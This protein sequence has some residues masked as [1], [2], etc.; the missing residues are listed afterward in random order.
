MNFTESSRRKYAFLRR[1]AMVAAALLGVCSL[2]TFG[3]ADII[4]AT[5][6]RDTAIQKFTADGES[7]V[8]SSGVSSNSAYSW[9]FTFDSLGNSYVANT[10]EGSID[11]ITPSG[12]RSVYASGLGWPTNLAFDN[13]GN[14][15]AANCG[16]SSIVKI[17]PDGS[18]SVFA[19]VMY[20]SRGLAFDGSGNLYVGTASA[21]IM[22]FTP[23]GVGAVFARTSNDPFSL[24]F[25][26]SGNLYAALNT[27]GTIERITPGG[28]SSVFASGLKQPSS[29][30]FDSMGNLFVGNYGGYVYNSN[31]DWLG[32][33][34]YIEKITPEG[35][36]SVFASGLNL[37]PLALAVT[38]DAGNPLSLPNDVSVNHAPVVIDN[39]AINDNS[40]GD[41]NAGGQPLALAPEPSSVWALLALCIPVVSGM[42]RQ[43]LRV[44]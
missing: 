10:S 37:L 21:E 29:L 39:P 4:Y 3:R 28:V 20:G 40:S 19:S 27:P 16:S 41:N 36:A 23:D 14:L 34:S 25:D 6:V 8:F 30:A 32:Y 38:D 17:T 13:V 15:Y 5:S 35:A 31:G 12:G 22:K 33:N 42:I 2:S 43:R 9:G 26:S 24:A 44:A 18:T 11:K 1:H 7:T